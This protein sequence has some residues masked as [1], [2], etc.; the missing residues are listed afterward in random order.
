VSIRLRPSERMLIVGKTQ[1]G[2]STLATALARRWERVLVYDPKHDPGAVPPGAAIRYGVEAALAALPGRV[3]Y[4]PIPRE[5]GDVRRHFDR[6]VRRVLAS[7]GA[8]GIVIH[9]L[10]DVSPTTGSGTF[11]SAAWRQGASQRVPIIA[12]AQRPHGIDVSAVSEAD[13]FALFQLQYPIDFT[14]VSRL[15]A[16]DPAALSIH[17]PPYWFHHRGPDGIVRLM[18]PIE[19]T[20][21]PESPPTDALEPS[22]GR[23]H[24]FDRGRRARRFRVPGR[25]PRAE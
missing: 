16:L 4:R 12:C 6:L 17:K 22:A 11:L 24:R 14:L 9:E 5:Q 15:F 3:V 23:H 18:P 7:G 19:W 10:R 20:P 25:R 8:H 1:S 2:K 21:A 13:H